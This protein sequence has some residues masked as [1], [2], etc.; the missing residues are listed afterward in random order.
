M[1]LSL[2]GNR[3]PDAEWVA[4]ARRGDP[5]AFDTLVQR[6]EA[7]LSRFLAARLS[8]GMDVEDVFQEAF[9]A[10]WRQLPTFRGKCRFKTWLF[11][12]AL[13]LAANRARKERTLRDRQVALEDE[14]LQEPG[15]PAG[16]ERAWVHA[17]EYADLRRRLKEQPDPGRQ[18]LE[19]YYYGD[20][21]LRE[22]AELLEVNL[23]TLKYWFYQ[24]HQ[25]LRAQLAAEER[26]AV[27]QTAEAPR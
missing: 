2:F 17:L 11:G 25:R 16:D 8:N 13:N 6:H 19:L 12:I 14:R 24:A 26:R 15:D 21:T 3:D 22:I 23:S 7:A 9:V 27:K 5:R 10:A 18:V 20:L 1:L 4:A